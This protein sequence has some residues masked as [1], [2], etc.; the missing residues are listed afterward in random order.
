MN[1]TLSKN[2]PLVDYV[3]KLML[4]EAIKLYKDK[5]IVAIHWLENT[6]FRMVNRLGELDNEKK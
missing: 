6:M 2:L 5:N 1:M 4:L 3:F